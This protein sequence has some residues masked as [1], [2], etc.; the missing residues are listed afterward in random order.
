MS[1]HPT[2]ESQTV[3]KCADLRQNMQRDMFDKMDDQ[4]LTQMTAMGEIKEGIAY[5]KGQEEAK[6]VGMV[7]TSIEKNNG[8][9]TKAGWKDVLVKLLIAFGPYILLFLFLGIYQWLKAQG[10]L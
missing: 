3:S 8:H 7:A 6:I 5:R 10:W 1:E 9:D 4:H 2:P